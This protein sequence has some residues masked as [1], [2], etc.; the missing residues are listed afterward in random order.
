MI[1]G[2][3]GYFFQSGTADPGQLVPTGQHKY[4]MPPQPP[5][6]AKMT[7]NLR[8]K[9]NGQIHLA[10]PQQLQSLTGV[11]VKERKFRMGITFLELLTESESIRPSVPKAAETTTLP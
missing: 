7:R 5:V 3:S 8:F 6:T 2:Y 11:T 4:K 1:K 10:F 9:G